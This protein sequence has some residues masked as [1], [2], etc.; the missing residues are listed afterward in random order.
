[1]SDITFE[2]VPYHELNPAQQEN[3]NYHKVSARLADFGYTTI[4]LHDDFEGADFIAKHVRGKKL[5]K[6]Q[7][8]GRLTFDKKYHRGEGE[9]D[10]YVAF[11]DGEDWYVYPHDEVFETITSRL[12]IIEGTKSWRE[13][14]TYHIGSLT[15]EQESILAPYRLPRPGSST[16]GS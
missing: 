13:E 16:D 10:I 1:V 7:L 5:L 15:D 14:G 11:P 6:V 4:R 2:P 3:Y 9:D 12:G 8:K